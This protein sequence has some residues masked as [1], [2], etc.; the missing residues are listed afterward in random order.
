MAEGA[1]C[2]EGALF[3][4]FLDDRY[5]GIEDELAFKAG[6]LIGIAAGTVD[7]A[8]RFEPPGFILHADIKVILAVV[9]SRVDEARAGLR[10]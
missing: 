8:Q 5:V 4:Q 6:N 1:F 2:K 9:R 3:S 7:S 10:A